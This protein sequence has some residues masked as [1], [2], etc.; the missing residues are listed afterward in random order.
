MQRAANAYFQTQVTTTSQ[1][2]LLVMLY[3]GAI[4]FLNQAKDHLAANDMAKKGIAISKAL[5]VLN[6][7]E[8]TLNMEKGGE[9]ARNLHGLYVFCANH[10]VRAN[11]KKDAAMIDEVIK[12][13]L[14][15][16][17]AYAQILS[18]PEAQAAAQE[19]AAQMRATAI[20]PPRVQPGQSN[21]GT[22]TPIN[23]S[24]QRQRNQYLINDGQTLSA[25]LKEQA[26]PQLAPET[27][28]ATNSDGGTKTAPATAQAPA[29]SPSAPSP[30]V[31]S[32]PLPAG[33]L[34]NRQMNAG[35]YRKFSEH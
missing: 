7:L 1:G 13:L 9:L 15:I 22:T 4:K 18:L 6:E 34:F 23:G 17:S 21:T 19:A 25:P 20:M 27:R 30:S 5:D 32:P 28:P 35:L 10:L 12:I 33:G 8:S 16:R 24:G 31:P 11:L 2:D 26:A 29:P 3:D 14:G